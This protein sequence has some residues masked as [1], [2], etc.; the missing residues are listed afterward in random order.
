[1]LKKG[2]KKQRK[3]DSDD[4][5]DGGKKKDKNIPKWDFKELAVGNTFSGTSYYRAVSEAG[6]NVNTRCQGKDIT[7]S[8]SI[9]ECQMYNAGV[10]ATEE[11]LCLTKVAKIIEEAN[12]A[13]FTVCFTAKVDD[14]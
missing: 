9:L 6:D 7:V 5:M 4:E 10:Y 12:T 11:K 13:C 8:K 1:M 3:D 2:G 14:K